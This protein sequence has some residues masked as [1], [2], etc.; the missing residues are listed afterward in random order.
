MGGGRGGSWGKKAACLQASCWAGPS[1][2][3]GGEGVGL[4]LAF[5]KPLTHTPAPA[6]TPYGEHEAGEG[7]EDRG[8]RGAELRQPPLLLQAPLVFARA[9]GNTV[10]PQKHDASYLDF[11]PTLINNVENFMLRKNIA[12]IKNS[13]SFKYFLKIVTLLNPKCY[14]RG[15]SPMVIIPVKPDIKE[16]APTIIGL[17][18]QPII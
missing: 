1:A 14:G 18:A 10:V 17:Q 5:S 3:G 9:D 13:D 6:A 7:H 15:T 12:T 8:D 11:D 16:I 2:A 4:P